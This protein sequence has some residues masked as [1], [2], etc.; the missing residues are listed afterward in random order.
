MDKNNRNSLWL[1]SQYAVSLVLSLVGLKLNLLSF[2][3]QM[4]SIWLLIFSIWGVGGV[5]DFGFS[6]SIVRFVARDRHDSSKT[7]RI[8][9]T[10]FFLF[11]LLGVGIFVVGCVCA[12]AF[13]LHNVALVPQDFVHMARTICYLSGFVFYA[14]YL[15]TVF[16]AIFEGHENFVLTSKVALLYNLTTFSAVAVVYFY[17]LS[18]ICLA[19]LYSLSA[20]MQLICYVFAFKRRLPTLR[21]SPSLASLSTFRHIFKFSASVQITYFLGSL[22]DPITKYIIG[23]NSQNRLVPPYEIARRFSLAVSG[24]FSFAFRNALPSTSTLISR[25]EQREY[26]CS[27]GV[28][29]SK[30][31]V[32]YSGIFFGVLSVVFCLFFKYFYKSDD[33][34]IIFLVL[35]LAESVNNTG[36]IL[37]TF[38]LGIGRAWFLTFLQLS[39]VVIGATCLWIGFAVWNSVLGLLG[40]FLSVVMGNIGMMLVIRYQT[41]V[42][43]LSFYKQTNMLKL[44][45]LNLL[46][47]SSA[48]IIFL[49]HRL[50]LVSQIFQSAGC[51]LLFHGEIMLA[52]KILCRQVARH[53]PR[54]P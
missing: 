27:H 22:I 20:A 31:G 18:I 34:I 49:D 33:S 39:N 4:F 21:I 25:S 38:I 26:V 42:G 52:C 6:V 40:Y 32:S 30:L 37:Y 36:F 1:A 2:G 43:L 45:V 24:L 12:E 16:R 51:V 19:V 9:S 5:V 44:L 23:T 54:H 11:L 53:L 3:G 8:I 14:S 17:H 28:R 47:L 41:E 7:N 50:W 13:Y 48:A 29:L 35:A 10:G 15:S 46:M